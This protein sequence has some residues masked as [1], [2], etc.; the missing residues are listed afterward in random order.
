M[1]WTD[2]AALPDVDIVIGLSTA[3]HWGEVRHEGHRGTNSTK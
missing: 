2:D 3:E 1:S